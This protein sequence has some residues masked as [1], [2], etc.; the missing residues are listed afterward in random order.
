MS[1]LIQKVISDG[2][3]G[4]DRGALDA[5]IRLNIS[6]GGWC[7]LDRRA[8]DG[9][10]PSHYQLTETELPDYK[11]R[12]E[13]NV[14]DSD[15]TLI[16]ARGPLIGGSFMT[17]SF[18]Y[19][20]GKPVHVVD[21]YSLTSEQSRKASVHEARQWILKSDVD[22]LNVAGPRESHSEGIAAEATAYL[23]N[24]LNGNGEH[25]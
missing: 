23:V 16:L 25:S 22:V 12:T 8:E 11:A 14:V 6:H 4:V 1:N 19:N 7:P 2:Q 18:A 10:I 9:P 5:A 13:R 17:H 15:A 24:L 20:H 21:L 3:T